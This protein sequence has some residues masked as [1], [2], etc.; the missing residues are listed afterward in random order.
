MHSRRVDISLRGI[1]DA[2]SGRIYYI[3]GK[4]ASHVFGK[5]NK[6]IVGLDIG[7]SSIKLVEIENDK[8][9]YTLVN[10]GIAELDPETIVDGEIMDRQLVVE[11]I[12]NLYEARG[13]SRKRVV[14]G[15]HG[16]GVIVKKIM[17]ERLPEEDASEAIYWEAEQ[18]VPYD[19]ND[20]SLDFQILG[21][22][23]GPK[24]M[25]VLLVAAKRE[26]ILNLI[27]IIREAGLVPDA[28]DVNSFAVQNV[29]ETVHDI[30]PDETA[31]LL[32]V[33]AEITNVNIVREG[34]PLYTQDVA[35]GV[36]N[37]I[38]SAQKRFQ[39]S[40]EEAMAALETGT[41]RY[42]IQPLI[43]NACK[44]LANVLDKSATYL[45]T[46]ADGENLDRIFLAGGAALMPAFVETLGR[47]QDL[48]IEI[49]DPLGRLKYDPELFAGTD[50]DKVAPQLTVG[51]GLALRKGRAA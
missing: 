51:V 15:V 3:G 2:K 21:V 13:I 14:V 27:E 16:R 37:I 40:R 9:E 48:P 49:I 22:D 17:M 26:M 10:Y 31:V 39:I 18:H 1:S 7:A 45:K 12:Q 47:I 46:A 5:R 6:S 25:Q 42:D 32:D 35:Q 29:V 4:E 34:I 44:D 30:R 50:P 36:N 23:I 43:E 19:I 28:V 11:T 33:G 41:D 20:V 24:Q 8:E 38:R